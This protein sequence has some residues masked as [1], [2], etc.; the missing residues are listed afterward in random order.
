MNRV[1]EATASPIPNALFWL[2]KGYPSTLI[3]DPYGVNA[4]QTQKRQVAAAAEGTQEIRPADILE[5]SIPTTRRSPVL[6][7][8]DATQE[9]EATDVLEVEAAAPNL[10]LHARGYAP[11]PAPP[12]QAPWTGAAAPIFAAARGETPAPIPSMTPTPVPPAAGEPLVIVALAEEPM[13]PRASDRWDRSD[14]EMVTTLPAPPAPP[15]P[16]DAGPDAGC[17]QD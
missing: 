4:D 9:I 13:G 8:V 17:P 14:R 7:L 12:V 5:E 11:P 10:G 3:F 1:V 6:E 16:A 15:P 2:E